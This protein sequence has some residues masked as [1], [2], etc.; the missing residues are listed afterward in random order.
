MDYR[1]YFKKMISIDSN[2]IKKAR[3]IKLLVLDVDGVL[4]D[5]GIILSEDGKESKRFYA[6]DGHGLMLAK[7]LNIEL[8]IIKGVNYPKGL[9]AWGEEKTFIWVEKKMDEL[10]GNYKEDRYR[11]SPLVR[12]WSNKKK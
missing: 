4:T 11:C 3:K 5:G 7:N 1:E 10:Y 8:A 9:I 12:Q 6:Q 2:L